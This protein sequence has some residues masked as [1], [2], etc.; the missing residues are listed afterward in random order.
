[1]K[2]LDLHIHTL[3]TKSDAKFEFDLENLKKYVIDMDL[4]G[5]AITNHNLFDIN[6]YKLIAEKLD[7]VI[8]FPGIEINLEGGHLLL[9]SEINSIEEFSI[10]CKKV[11]DLIEDPKDYITLKQLKEIYEDLSK[12]L[13]IPHYEKKPKI[14]KEIIEDIREYISCGEVASIKD[15][16]RLNKDDKSLTPVW[17]SDLRAGTNY[18][19]FKHGVTYLDIDNISINE[20]KIALKDKTK[21]ALSKNEGNS[22]FKI[23]KR[24]LFIS[25]GLNVVIGERSSGKTYLLDYIYKNFDNVKYIKQFSLLEKDEEKAVEAF[26]K[27]IN[28]NKSTVS[29]QY[30]AEFKNV[31]E[32]IADID[33]DILSKSMD[34]YIS[35]LKKYAEE[36]ERKD[37]FSSAKLFNDNK[38]SIEDL[39]SLNNLILS[40]ETILKNTE[41]KAVIN[42][43]IDRDKLINLADHLVTIFK[44]KSILNSKKKFIN[45]LM[46]DIKSKL[47]LQTSSTFI[48]NIELENYITSIDKINKFEQL[49]KMIKKERVFYEADIKKFVINGEIKEFSGAQELKNLSGSTQAFSPAYKK[50]GNAY[51]YLSEI[52]KLSIPKSD[53]Y[54]YF[55]KID[56]NVKN[57]YGFNVSGGER[58]EF[59]LLTE[60]QDALK[61]DLLLIDEPESSFDNLFLKNDVNQLIKRISNIIPVVIVTHNN[62]VGISIKP[63][64]LI[65]TKREILENNSVKYKIYLG[66]PT[67]NRMIDEEGNK[68]SSREII[69]NCL[70][71]GENTYEERRENYELLKN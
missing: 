16:L 39:N 27:K 63:D 44:E 68:T 19:D 14:R 47:R 37:S 25:T 34:S 41:Y 69:L 7:D 45:T 2:G 36:I 66:Y 62:T 32:E 48:E 51:N 35:T 67:S 49:V 26:S 12:Y 50:Y 4:H 28:Y 57:K 15:F 18:D 40:I 29:E 1:M 5:I 24:R 43:F 11:E 58:A 30:L 17:F 65:C 8:V 31:V 9:V 46:D 54:K 61:Y 20:I 59:N 33:L 3:A 52:K 60:I 22:L 42:E 10:K 53:Y 38:Y 6:Q 64:Y 70:E 71:A 55:V 56:Y 13:L 21:V 23:D